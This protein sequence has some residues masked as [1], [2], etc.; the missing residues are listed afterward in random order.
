M[1]R[2]LAELT[3]RKELLRSR[4]ALDRLEARAAWLQVRSANPFREAAR[5]LVGPPVRSQL[6]DLA[7]IALGSTRMHRAARWIARGV[8]AWKLWRVV[9][10][11]R[12][13]PARAPESAA[14]AAATEAPD[15]I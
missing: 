12:P 4:C 3:A 2:R 11:L 7:A 5:A 1:S 10:S 8:I 14:R 6:I 13:S 15:R 9:S